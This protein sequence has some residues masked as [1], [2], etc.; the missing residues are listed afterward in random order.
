M[1]L[2]TS[3]ELLALL[4]SSTLFWMADCITITPRFGMPPLPAPQSLHYNDSPLDFQLVPGEGP[5]LFQAW[6]IKCGNISDSQGLEVGGCDLLC[7]P[8]PDDLMGTVPWMTA[9]AVKGML[10]GA[11]VTIQQ[12]FFTQ[13]SMPYPVG[14]VTIF[15]GYISDQGPLS[16]MTAQF[17]VKNILE[18]LNHKWPRNLY[19]P[20]CPW[21]V[22]STA[23]GLNQETFAVNGTLSGGTTT[24]VTCPGL[25]Q[26]DG[27]FDLGM[28][29]FNDGDNAGTW[30]TI[31][32]YTGPF[33]PPIGPSRAPIIEVSLPLLYVPGADSVTLYP[34]CDGAQGTCTAKFNNL[35]NFRG[36]P[37]VPPTDAVA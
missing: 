8:G 13:E 32:S 24:T 1:M 10:M 18:R 29:K 20:S 16:A 12:A 33:S 2:D 34:G 4:N 35:A 14:T 11:A 21:V 28:I 17:K 25:T 9:A 22:Y 6:R 19:G 7:H 36:T 15:K 26:P 27:Y 3:P 37:N 31:K 23:C 30:R 5:A